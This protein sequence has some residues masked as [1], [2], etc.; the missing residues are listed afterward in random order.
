MS[1]SI[2]DAHAAHSVES[3][4]TDRNAST[5][6]G[7]E[8]AAASLDGHVIGAQYAV[9]AEE[10]FDRLGESED[11]TEEWDVMALKGIR[12]ASAV[13]MFV[14]RTDGLRRVVGESDEPRDFCSALAARL[15]D[16]ACAVRPA[17]EDRKR[18]PRPSQP[19]VPWGNASRDKPKRLERVRPV[20]ARQR[21]L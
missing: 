3:F 16:L 9:A 19:E 5:D 7:V 17:R 10:H 1:S 8:P 21:R 14:E 2:G 12:L 15:D 18:L 4:T 13:P 20:G 6:V 11:P